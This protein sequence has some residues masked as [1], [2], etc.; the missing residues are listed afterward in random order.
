MGTMKTRENLNSPSEMSTS[1]RKNPTFADVRY[2]FI[3]C[4]R[5]RRKIFTEFQGEQIE[6]Q[7]KQELEKLEAQLGFD[8]KQCHCEEDRVYLDLQ[9]PPTL[10]PADLMAKIK[11]KTS[12]VLRTQIVG[13]SH[14]QGLWTRAYFVTTGANLD[15]QKVEQF[16]A[17]QKTRS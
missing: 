1:H 15:P 10:S 17:Q 2:Q 9:A 6:R 7:F 8:V 13:L 16:L 11:M 14:L 12:R 3:F 4:A 5:Y